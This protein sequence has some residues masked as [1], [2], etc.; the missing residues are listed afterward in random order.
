V[1][2]FHQVPS[3][4]SFSVVNKVS[5]RTIIH[6]DQVYMGENKVFIITTTIPS[7]TANGPKTVEQMV[8]NK[9]YLRLGKFI[10]EV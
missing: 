6:F 10:R 4:T 7:Q 5:P 3:P 2:I 8:N 9:S 1:N